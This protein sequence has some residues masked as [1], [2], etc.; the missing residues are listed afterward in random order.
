MEM[1]KNKFPRQSFLPNLDQLRYVGSNKI[2]VISKF[3]IFFEASPISEIIFK[4]KEINNNDIIE[5]K[6]AGIL[7]VYWLKPNILK[8]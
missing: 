2:T 4:L 7:R 8:Y 6:I 5:Y 1:L 3:V